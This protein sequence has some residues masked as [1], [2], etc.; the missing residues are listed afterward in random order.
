MRVAIAI[1]LLAARIVH[2]QAPPP[3]AFEVA[4]V[5]L[6]PP[7]DPS[8]FVIRSGSPDPGGRWQAQNAT[9]LMLLQGAY[10]DYKKPG[11]IV[12][13]P[14]WLNER[15]FNI[16]AKAEGTPTTAQ[17][18]SMVRRLLADRFK[19]NVHVE[20][21]SVEVYSLIVAR[22]DGRL[23]PRLRP[24][25]REC[26]AELEA[27]QVRIK[28]ATGPVTFSSDDARPCKGG[29]GDSRSGLFRMAGGATLE[30]IAFGLQVFMD[31]RVVDRTSLQGIYEYELEFDYNATRSIASTTDDNPAGG[32]V[33]TAVQ[34]QLG[35]KL[36]R[37]RETVDV[38][39]IDSVEMPT[40]N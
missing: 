6:S 13:G 32:S 14:A 36:E 4:S 26:L 17:Y 38:L 21:R 19:L 40:E 11:M 7:L 23:G 22:S 20:P 12:G 1:V 34:E 25:S 18:Q 28:N 3:V 37:R 5:K 33:F 35:L 31:K 29:L 15:R 39:V 27:E 16:E 30:S 8:G 2:A 9:M 24:A 10:P